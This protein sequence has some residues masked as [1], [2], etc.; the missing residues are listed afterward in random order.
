LKVKRQ[1]IF[2]VLISSCLLVCV[3]CSPRSIGPDEA[4]SNLQTSI[5]LVAETEVF[6]TFVAERKSTP[7]FTRG[8]IGYLEQKVGSLE[9]Q[10]DQSPPE[11]SVSEIVRE[12]RA[13][14]V[15]LDHELLAVPAIME[16][17]NELL[18]SRAR[19]SAVR[20]RLEDIR[21]TR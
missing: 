4:K 12:C 18:A 19:I 10:L 8:H 1:I 15:V 17:K 21:S 6:L 20:K 3:G 9:K 7:V 13:Q 14:L 11:P 16:N 5:S 2:R